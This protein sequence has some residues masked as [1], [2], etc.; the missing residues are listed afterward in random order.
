M[1]IWL[2]DYDSI[3]VVCGVTIAYTPEAYAAAVERQRQ[4]I[5]N[6]P[7]RSALMSDWDNESRD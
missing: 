2:D 5:I 3:R 7:R 1:N 6:A 4:A